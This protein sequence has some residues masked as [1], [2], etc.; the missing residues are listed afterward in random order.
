MNHKRTLRQHT[1]HEE[2]KKKGRMRPQ[3]K[4]HPIGL[5]LLIAI[6]LIMSM[7]FMMLNLAQNMPSVP[8]N[9][10]PLTSENFE[11]VK[12]L[13]TYKNHVWFA[14]SSTL[15]H[16][17]YFRSSDGL[18]SMDIASLQPKILLKNP[19]IDHFDVTTPSDTFVI[20]KRGH[21]EVLDSKMTVLHRID[22]DGSVRDVALTPA[23][24]YLVVLT[25]DDHMQIWNVASGVLL[26]TIDADEAFHVG[27]S[28]DNKT[29][30][31]AHLNDNLKLWDAATWRTTPL[32]AIHHEGVRSIAYNHD[33]TL[34]A[35]GNYDGE[36]KIWNTNDGTLRQQ[37]KITGPVDSLVFSD[38]EKFL[39]ATDI[40][41]HVY[42]LD[43]QTGERVFRQRYDVLLGVYAF[44][45]PG[46]EYLVIGASG[47]LQFWGITQ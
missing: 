7:V 45:T 26:Y 41:N 18:F 19:D 30:A 44:L 13:Y 43:M 3:L 21:I 17:I 1:E 36:I 47:D 24:H 11:D 46:N 34:L 29:F 37:F 22:P 9:T 6:A 38:D 10:I 27:V 8:K 42:V 4:L 32:F 40:D 2:I 16:Q 23:N 15:S 5:A 25:V 35:S 12:L 14:K 33:G 28:P 20:L 31:T 39:V